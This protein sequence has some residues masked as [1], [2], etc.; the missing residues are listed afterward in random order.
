MHTTD[1]R[2]APHYPPTLKNVN[3][4]F[5]ADPISMFRR[6]TMPGKIVANIVKFCNVRLS[7][8]TTV[9]DKTNRLTTEGEIMR[10]FG[11]MGA[12][13]QNQQCTM[14]QL[15]QTERH[16]DSFMP[17]MALGQYGMGIK[18]LKKLLSMIW[19]YWEVD[20]SDL[21]KTDPAR[22]HNVS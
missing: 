9:K 17:A 5:T 21:D 4:A 1:A 19:M 18:R 6:V 3:V 12:I 14:E 2:S 20:E 16:D 7:G 10:V 22:Y 13:A 8:D 11:Y 15:F